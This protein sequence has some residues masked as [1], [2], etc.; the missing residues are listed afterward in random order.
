MEALRY[1]VGLINEDLYILPEILRR[2]NKIVCTG[3]VIY[4]YRLSKGSIM[5]SEYTF[6]RLDEVEAYISVLEYLKGK[7][8]A[9]VEREMAKRGMRVFA[10][11]K[12]VLSMTAEQ[13]KIFKDK[14]LRYK[15]A[16]KEVSFS[17]MKEHLQVFL[18]SRLFNVYMLM[19]GVTER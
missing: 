13:K 15:K 14:Y 18:F 5:R 6:K 12:K 7:D 11:S 1:H 10:K 4:N 17:G 16:L 2:S 8:M 19:H 3:K 9:D